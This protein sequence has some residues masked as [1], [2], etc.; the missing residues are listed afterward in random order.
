MAA[1]MAVG[2]NRGL[3]SRE[4]EAM[5]RSHRAPEDEFFCEKYAVWYPMRDC[6]FRVLHRT[7]EGCVSCFQGRVNLRRLGPEASASRDGAHGPGGTLL[8]FPAPSFASRPASNA[9]GI[10]PRKG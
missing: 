5:S 7:F 1:G 8:M 9:P 4:P 6:N 2:Y 3:M 10:A